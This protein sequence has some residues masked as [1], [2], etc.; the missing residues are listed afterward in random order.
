MGKGVAAGKRASTQTYQ[1]TANLSVPR[2]I[3]QER[4]TEGQ[5]QKGLLISQ[6]PFAC[7]DFAF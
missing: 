1:G 2:L 4:K 5:K 3:G 7:L 6:R